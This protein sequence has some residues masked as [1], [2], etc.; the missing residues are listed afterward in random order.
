ML[1][2][3]QKKKGDIRRGPKLFLKYKGFRFRNIR[4]K[5][6]MLNE[7]YVN[8]DFQN[9]LGLRICSKDRAHRN[10]VFQK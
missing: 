8:N 1:L 9:H 5:F 6:E 10:Q 4:N 7:D 2:T 3:I